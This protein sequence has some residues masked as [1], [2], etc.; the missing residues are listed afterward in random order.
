MS[1]S[2]IT[3]EQDVIVVGAGPTG[4]ALACELAAAG[5]ACTVLERRAAPAEGWRSVTL[6]S[7][8]MELL[9]LRGHAE[10][11]AGAGRP[12]GRMAVGSA[13]PIDFSGLDSPFPFVNVIPQSRT[14]E[15]L[16]RRALDLGVTL[17]R[18]AEVTELRQDGEGVTLRVRTPAGEWDERAGYVVGCDGAGSAVRE[19]AGIAF[20]GH[21]YTMAPLL[22]DVRL[23]RPLPRELLVL[24]GRGG[25]VVSV[26]YADGS[27]RLAVVR[28]DRGWREEAAT[29]EEFR[30]LLAETLGHDPEPYGVRWLARFKIHQRIA[31]RY[32]S[33]RVLLAGDAAHLHSPLGGQGLNLGIQD[34]VN[35]GWKLA[36]EV[37]G[38]A[39]PGLLD[40][41]EAER[42]PQAERTL[43]ATDRATRLAVATSPGRRLA[44][45]GALWRLRSARHR[46]RAAEM[47]TG[48]RGGHVLAPGARLPH[49]AV[50]LP[51]RRPVPAGELT[52]DGRF[53]LLDLSADGAGAELAEPWGGRVCV[54]ATRGPLPGLPGVAVLLVRPDAHVAWTTSEPDPAGLRAAL[55]HH[56]G[57]A[58]SPAGR[59]AP[60]DATPGREGGAG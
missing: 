4:L 47:L 57:P 30:D 28:A 24:P 18:E 41:Y 23:R 55:L 52:R 13:P 33:G 22:A 10:E 26:P 29:L 42:R 43:A 20:H 5:A 38:R 3:P 27:Y 7:R 40:S 49:V 2:P 31:D 59:A 53:L 51:G 12:V 58:E 60:S 54:V 50:P 36:A 25:I 34:A 9:H 17:Q 48:L 46:R 8:T 32:R 21:T 45:R 39:A 44:R 1:S 37:R 35:L 11:L 14:E 19:L 15:V 6:Y 16:Q 56:C